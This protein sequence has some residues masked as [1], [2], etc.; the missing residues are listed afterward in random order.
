EASSEGTDIIQSSVTYTASSN[1]ENLTLTG[2]SAING[3]GNTLDN[4][5][6]G[7]SGANTLSGGSGNDALY[8]KD[9]LDTL[10]GGDG[11][12]IFVFEAATA[13]NNIDVISDFSTGAGDAIDLSD[14][15][16]SYN[17]GVDTLTDWVKIEDSGS[18]SAVSVDRD[19]TGGTYSWTQMA[20][21]AG[22]TGL[23]NE[24]ALVS[25][26]NLIVA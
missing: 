16:T 3:T 7:N 2:S 14:L 21:I 5:I 6:I 24:A 22:V 13:Y 18:D 23:T 26:G 4:V 17:P 9:G 12:D 19:G 11:A 1:V 8:G 15:L 20:T 25:S 10:T